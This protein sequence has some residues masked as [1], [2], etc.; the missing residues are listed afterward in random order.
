MTEA[1]GR[2]VGHAKHVR[3]LAFLNIL[4][5]VASVGIASFVGV[6]AWGGGVA[7]GF[8]GVAGALAVGIA[9]V[10]AAFV[11]VGIGLLRGVR[12]ARPAALGLGLLCLFE[13][14]VGTPLG[15]YAIWLLVFRKPAE[16]TAG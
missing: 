11:L 8:E 9:L 7:R 16:P 1:E 13:F 6:G 10:G 15:I 14:P 3:A 4:H 2:S 5:G 12:A